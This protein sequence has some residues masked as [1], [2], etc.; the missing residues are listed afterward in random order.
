MLGRLTR[1]SIALNTA[2][3]VMG[4]SQPCA[5]MCYIDSTCVVKLLLKLLRPVR[6]PPVQKERGTFT[7]TGIAAA[8]ID[9]RR[10]AILSGYCDFIVMVFR[11]M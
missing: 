1:G 6:F 10:I 3:F 5:V 9:S 11:R 8:A 7:A 4:G 2:G